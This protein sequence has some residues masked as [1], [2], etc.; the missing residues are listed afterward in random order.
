[1]PRAIV[2]AAAP[3]AREGTRG[4]PDDGFV[5]PSREEVDAYADKLLKLIPAEVIGVYL[6][7][8]SILQGAGNIHAPVPWLVFIFGIFA[9]WFYLRFTL[10]VKETRQLVLTALAFCIWAFTIGG[11]FETLEWYRDAGG[12][13]A[14][15]LLAGYTFMAPQIRITKKPT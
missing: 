9:T 15:L 14:G 13:Y 4:V 8:T 3:A 11:P 1:M 6:A 10:K 2:D 12:T 5:A 7:M